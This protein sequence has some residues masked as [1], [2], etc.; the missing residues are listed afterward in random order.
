MESNHFRL[1]RQGHILDIHE[2]AGLSGK[3]VIVSQSCDIVQPKREFIQLAP[4]V[5]LLDEVVLRGALKKENPRFA[6]VPASEGG[7][8]ADLAQIVSVPKSYFA[9]TLEPVRQ[10]PED[11]REA[12]EF[13]LAVGRWFGR[14]AVPDEVQPWLAPVQN[15]I[16][17]KYDNPNSPLGQVMQR[18]AEVRVEAV[19]WSVL[20]VSLTLHV[21]VKAGCLPTVSEDADLSNVGRLPSQLDELCSAILVENDAVRLAVLWPTLAEVLASRCVP[22]V[23]DAEDASVRDAVREIVGEVSSDDEFPLSKARR[24]EQ[25]DIDFLSE[26]TPY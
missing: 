14:F 20:P 2:V 13:G 19:D 1:L 11:L 25:L 17:S 24:S 26:P 23:K 21:I 8:F 22:R 6:L 7:A 4:V 3:Y 9:A 18:V 16:R 5:Q 15:L 12:R 10:G